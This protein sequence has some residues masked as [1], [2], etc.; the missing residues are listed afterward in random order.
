M[1]ILSFVFYKTLE[2]VNITPAIRVSIWAEENKSYLMPCQFKEV[3][4]EGNF[5]SIKA[6][7]LDPD[8]FVSLKHVDKKF[9]FGHPGKVI[10]FGI[11]KEMK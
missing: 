1:A 4:K 9:L 3:S 11:M 5:Y 6:E 8:E 7:V 2:G 10:G